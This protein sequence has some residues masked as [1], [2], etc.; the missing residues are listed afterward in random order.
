[1]ERVRKKSLIGTYLLIMAAISPDSLAEAVYPAD[2]SISAD[3]YRVAIAGNIYSRKEAD[4]RSLWKKESNY[5]FNAGRSTS[6]DG[7]Y[8]LFLDRGREAQLIDRLSGE[9]VSKSSSRVNEGSTRVDMAGGFAYVADSKGLH[10]LGKSERN[11]DVARY[12]RL[13]RQDSVELFAAIES[14]TFAGCAFIITKSGKAMLAV[15]GQSKLKKLTFNGD[16]S[17]L[18]VDAGAVLSRPGPDGQFVFSS[19][20]YSLQLIQLQG[21]PEEPQ[22]AGMDGAQRL[23]APVKAI[24]PWTQINAP[25]IVPMSND[26]APF[27]Y[28]LTNG[29][30]FQWLDQTLRTRWG[31]LE[32]PSANLTPDGK[33][34]LIASDNKL[35]M[36]HLSPRPDTSDQYVAALSAGQFE[37]PSCEPISCNLS[38]DDSGNLLSVQVSDFEDP[39]APGTHE[40]FDMSGKWTLNSAAIQK[41]EPGGDLAELEKQLQAAFKSDTR[42]T[43]I[44]FNETGSKAYLPLDAFGWLEFNV[45]SWNEAQQISRDALR[46][47]N[48][49]FT[50]DNKKVGLLAVDAFVGDETVP[51]FSLGRAAPLYP[52]IGKTTMRTTA[53]TPQ[54]RE[55]V[56]M[57]AAGFRDE[58]LDAIKAGL[59]GYPDQ[60]QLIFREIDTYPASYPTWTQEDF[61]SMEAARLLLQ[62]YEELVQDTEAL[63]NADC[64]PVLSP[65]QGCKI[66]SSRTHL[67]AVDQV[68]TSV[69]GLEV[70]HASDIDA[71]MTR[72]NR[73]EWA[74]RVGLSDGNSLQIPVVRKVRDPDSLVWALNLY[75]QMAMIQGQVKGPRQVQ[76]ALGELGLAVPEEAKDR[77]ELAVMASRVL[78]GKADEIYSKLLQ[79]RDWARSYATALSEEVL[80][81]PLR[82]NK[83]KLGFIL[84]LRPEEITGPVMNPYPNDEYV[85][86]DGDILPPMSKNSS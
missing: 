37:I 24:L 69:N 4:S 5:Q 16:T 57:F 76:K 68:I 85:D 63:L 53:M 59:A 78:T 40:L 61:T 42:F 71:A 11:R 13:R 26:Q 25:L 84:G 21:D 72:L 67:L 17:S 65:G 10:L 12:F 36:F 75:V 73:N 55:A 66:I 80:Y 50:T 46:L 8:V 31:Q 34:L 74:A 44:V 54:L 39:K 19:D 28:D 32:N 18:K 30:K 38:I 70:R 79:R 56:D 48:W 62:V 6:A 7:R 27:F 81:Y 86:F 22:L 41:V 14:G 77:M 58:G 35:Q 9:L 64:Q 20:G 2:E 29:R 3:L 83:K 23:S 49:K 1:M 47:S 45:A 82:V 60:L 52:D 51:R 33:R 43:G 15:P